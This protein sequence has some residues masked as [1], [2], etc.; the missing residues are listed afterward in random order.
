VGGTDTSLRR[1]AEW[2]LKEAERA[3]AN[4]KDI[5]VLKAAYDAASTREDDA[6]GKKR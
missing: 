6:M 4:P 2:K 5:A 1:D 3:G